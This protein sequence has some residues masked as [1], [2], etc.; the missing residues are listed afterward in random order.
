MRKIKVSKIYIGVSLL[1]M[2]SLIGGCGRHV[3]TLRNIKENV[4]AEITY[5]DVNV[6]TEEEMKAYALERL[7]EK[8]KQAFEIEEILAYG[9]QD[10][11]EDMPMRLNGKAHVVGDE[12]LYCYFEVT[13]PHLFIDEYATNYYKEDITQYARESIKGVSDDYEIDIEHS[14][15]AQ[16]YDPKMDYKEYLYDG[17]CHIRYTV[18]VEDSEDYHTYIP[19]I[20]KW[21]D[22]LY[23]LDYRWFFEVCDKDGKWYFTLD[24]VD[25][26]FDSSDDWD[27]EMIYDSI[28]DRVENRDFY[29][30]LLNKKG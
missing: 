17:L 13:Q 22:A 8:Y 30:E 10:G 11:E 27:D 20:R 29:D 3:S 14:L 1:I 12:N 21:M 7:Q 18:Y 15:T 4:E 6:S 5:K 23:A 19:L 28:V 2:S 9:H 25:N 16:V 26:G 24:P